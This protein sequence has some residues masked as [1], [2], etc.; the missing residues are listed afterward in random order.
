M[1][2]GR[3]TPPW[4]AITPLREAHSLSTPLRFRLET[5][6][7]VDNSDKRQ[8]FGASE[9]LNLNVRLRVAKPL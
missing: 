8:I 5:Y 3:D 2:E 4:P 1:C 6:P 7:Q 9:A